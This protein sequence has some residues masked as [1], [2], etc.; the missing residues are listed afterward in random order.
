MAL[1]LLLGNEHWGGKEERW[2]TVSN[3]FGA[4]ALTRY[5][6][7][8]RNVPLVQL[9]VGGGLQPYSPLRRFPEARVRERS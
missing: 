8:Y 9:Y 1:S 5:S 7:A 6:D 3:R 2:R 4:S